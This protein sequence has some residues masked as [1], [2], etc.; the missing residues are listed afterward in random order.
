MNSLRSL[1]VRSARMHSHDEHNLNIEHI[2]FF[3]IAETRTLSVYLP[4]E[5][6]EQSAA[7]AL[8]MAMIIAITE[9]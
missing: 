2:E 1:L 6:Q 9:I 4:N 3:E 5:H 7:S 8:Q